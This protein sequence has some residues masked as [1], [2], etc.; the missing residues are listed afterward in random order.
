MALLEAR[1]DRGPRPPYGACAHTAEPTRA[2]SQG[3]KDHSAAPNLRGGP[4]N[5]E[6]ASAIPGRTG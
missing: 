1:A 6:P 5:G 4:D 3:V 2:H